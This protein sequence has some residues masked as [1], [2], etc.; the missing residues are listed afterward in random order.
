[1]SS[2]RTIAAIGGAALVCLVVAR[3]DAEKTDIKA[4]GD[5]AFSFVGLKTWAW[6]PEGAG[7]VR[8]ALSPDADPTRVAARA[9]PVIQPAI[10][11][12]MPGRGFTK[13]ADQPDLYVHY[14]L[15]ATVNQASQV[16]GQFVAPMPT[17]GLPPFAPVTTSLEIYA[18]G[19]L[20]IDISS[21]KLNA[22]VWRGSASRKLDFERPDSERKKVAEKAITDL[23]KRF[24]P[25]PAKN[26]KK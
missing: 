6:H 22:I 12:E 20:I 13:T 16:M 5:P 8:L 26:K 2:I 21:P 24:P 23:L 3:L 9:D 17:W 19:T 15:L 4:D 11:R 7:D 14:Y 18:L 10:E 1:M 25:P